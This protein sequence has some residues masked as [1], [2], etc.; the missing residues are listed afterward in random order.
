MRTFVM[1]SRVLTPELSRR[2]DTCRVRHAYALALPLFAGMACAQNF[3]VKP[4]RIMTSDVGG[5][6]D[7]SARYIAQEIS[8]PLGQQVVV[9]NR[10]GGVVAGQTVSKASPDGYT[11]LYYGSSIWLLPLIRKDVPYTVSDFAPI[12]LATSSPAVLVVHPT[13][14]AKSV[15]ELIALA[16]SRPGELNYASAAIGTT[17]HLAAEL[18][19]HMAGVNIVRI[20]YKGTGGALSDLI[21]GQVQLTFAAGAAAAPHIRSGRMRALAVTRAQASAAYPDLPTIAASGLAGYEAISPIALFAPAGT[22]AAVIARLNQ[23]FVRALN[24]PEAKQRFLQ[25]GVEL[26]GSTAEKSLTKIR[27]EVERMG[28]VIKAAGIR[29][30]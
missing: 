1:I 10:G 12:T 15:K 18:F 23:E 7:V 8:G 14:P 9:E 27:S 20:T 21:A 5:G 26:V 29:D 25:A 3:P 19:K 30:E 28:G 2:I 4:I 11:L 17:N 22:P 13:L 24:K 6:A 16:R